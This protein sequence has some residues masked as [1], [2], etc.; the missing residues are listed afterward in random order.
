[1]RKSLWNDPVIAAGQV[2]EDARQAISFMDHQWPGL[3]RLSFAHAHQVCLA[4]LDGRQKPED[5]RRRFE[6]AVDEAQLH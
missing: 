5:T 1:M 6:Q 4:A 2:I 3:K